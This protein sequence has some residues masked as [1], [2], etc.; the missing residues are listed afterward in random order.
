VCGGRTSLPHDRGEKNRQA[1]GA[2]ASPL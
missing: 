2:G 1:L